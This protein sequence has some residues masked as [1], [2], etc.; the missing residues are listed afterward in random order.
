MHRVVTIVVVYLATLG[1]VAWAGV[2]HFGAAA[3]EEGGGRYAHRPFVHK[4]LA[5]WS[6]FDQGATQRSLVWLGDSTILGFKGPSYANALSQTLR[7]QG[8]RSRILGW[9]G[10]DFYGYYFLTTAVME[11]LHPDV[12][13][14]IAHLR[15]FA[16]RRTLEIEGPFV[17][18][19]TFSDLAS[20]LEPAALVETPGLP[21]AERGLTPP[22]LALAQALRS[23]RVE[24]LFRWWEGGRVLANRAV[25]FAIL[26]PPQPGGS[27]MTKV[28]AVRVALAESDVEVTPAQPIVRMMG[29]AVRHAVRRGACVVVIGTPL[30][31]ETMAHTVGYDAERYARRFAVLRRVVEENGG[32]FVDLHEALGAA[33]FSDTAGHFTQA[34]AD[35]M[36]LL[37]GDVVRAAAL[38]G[39]RGAFRGA[40]RLQ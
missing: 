38:E 31:H 27:L 35:H 24:Q 21:L 5:P 17:E 12:L 10:M 40:V 32:T 39:C 22:R 30:P 7:P 1:L 29:A 28:A 15:L 16:P 36:A 20:V 6:A 33:E 25:A 19:P 11:R 37:A 3:D 4:Q 34:G 13:V 14:L 9:L 18:R 2:R 26:G 23:A 8:V